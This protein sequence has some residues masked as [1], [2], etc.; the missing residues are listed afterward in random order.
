MIGAREFLITLEELGKFLTKQNNK[1]Q[2]LF[3]GRLEGEMLPELP[4]VA[5]PTSSTLPTPPP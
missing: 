2:R 1:K 3:K 4:P 5:S